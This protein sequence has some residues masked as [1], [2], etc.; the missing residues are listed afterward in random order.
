MGCGNCIIIINSPFF[1]S[2]CPNRI[3]GSNQNQN[4]NQGLPQ[5]PPD[6][7]G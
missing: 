4:Q 7:K 1:H 5:L 2:P 3:E 6:Y